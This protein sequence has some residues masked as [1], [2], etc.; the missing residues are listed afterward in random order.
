MIKQS[1]LR[2]SAKLFL[3]IHLITDQ[4]GQGFMEDGALPWQ[5]MPMH[6]GTGLGST[7]GGMPMHERAL[8]RMLRQVLP[9]LL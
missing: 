3:S 4:P 1:I 8:P 2:I 5:G 9:L 6:E 7:L